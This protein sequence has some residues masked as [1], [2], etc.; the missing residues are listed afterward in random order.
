MS[1]KIQKATHSGELKIGNLTIPCAVLENKTRLLTQEGFY[2]AIGRSGKP[3]A[4]RGS[5]IEKL[6]PFL[7]LNNLKPFVSEELANSTIPIQ[8]QPIK[9]GR[10]FGFKAELLPKVCEVYLRARDEKKLLKSQLKFA[11]A[12]DILMRG[13]AHVGIVALVDEATGY[14]ADRDRDEL[15]KILEAYISRELLPWTKRFPDEYYKELFNLRGWHFNPFSVKRPQ[16]VGKLTNK[17]VYDKLPKGVLEELQKKNPKTQKGYR[18]HR[19]HQFL[20][21]DIGNPHLEK[22]LAAVIAL[23]RVA[24]NW[25]TFERMLERAFPKSRIKQLELALADEAEIDILDS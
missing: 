7:D 16:L 20:T 14:Q 1:K 23:M 19:H 6:A 15:H 21:D 4:G 25:R 13:L 18:K 2:K 11:K 9:G 22:H 10:A 5:S 24:P 3:A 12:C 8:F 17:I